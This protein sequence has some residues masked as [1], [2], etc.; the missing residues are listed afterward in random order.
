MSS[1]SVLIVGETVKTAVS[2][3]FRANIGQRLALEDFRNRLELGL[4]I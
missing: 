4:E 2:E 1:P 3:K